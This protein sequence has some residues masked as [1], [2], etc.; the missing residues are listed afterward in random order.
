[1]KP[2]DQY[3]SRGGCAFPART[4][5]DRKS[6]S[7]NKERDMINNL[8]AHLKEEASEDAEHKGWC[9]KGKLDNGSGETLRPGVSSS[10]SKFTKERRSGR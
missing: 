6:N 2:G 9:N 5:S 3:L 4:T 7:F 8:I 1:M 10:R